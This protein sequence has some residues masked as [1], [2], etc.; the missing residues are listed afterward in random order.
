MARRGGRPEPLLSLGVCS[1]GWL[2][3]HL[4]ELIAAAARAQLDGEA[5]LHF[6]VRSDNLCLHDGRALLVDWNW[7]MR[8]NPQ[9]E[10]AGWLP[11]LHAEGGPAPEAILPDAPELAALVA[12]YFAAQAGLPPIEAAPGVRGV[13]LAQL[14]T[15]L[16]WAARA[17]E[18]EPPG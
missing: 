18:L 6:D 16:P 9:L 12:G 4:D 3:A 14:R 10:L 7:T 11:S 13:Q 8:G 15:A 5:L 1:A 17:L 2:E